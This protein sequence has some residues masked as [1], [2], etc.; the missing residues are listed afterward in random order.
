MTRNKETG[1]RTPETRRNE[2]R[3]DAEQDG[4]QKTVSRDKESDEICESKQENEGCL[5]RNRLKQVETIGESNILRG[6]G[7]WKET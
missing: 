4:A 3:S 1:N 2:E 6:V 5:G 7:R